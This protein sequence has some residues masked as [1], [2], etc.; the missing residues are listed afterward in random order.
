MLEI[1][2]LPCLQDNYVFLAHDRQSGETA[3]IDVPETAPVLEAL[4]ARGWTLSQILLTHH[5]P[6]HIDGVDAL[7]EATGAVVVGAK[8]DTHRLP[9]LD[10][11]VV[12][13]DTVAVGKATGMVLGVPGH[14]VG[15]IAYVFDGAIFT[16]DSLMAL[17]CGRLF[18]GSADQMWNSLRQFRTLPGETLVCS[19]HEYTQSNAR[20]ALSI[21]PHNPALIARAARIDTARAAGRPT[22]PSLLS[23]EIATNPFLRAD[24]PAIKAQLGMPDAPDTACF[25]EIRLRKNTF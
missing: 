10:H 7:R 3:C 18:E 6:D 1:V 22:V 13:G 24:D 14:T 11:S 12:P 17:G 5:H 4:V 8:A 9:K 2:T 19:G 15:H 23:D 21:D 16:G 20:F 25:A